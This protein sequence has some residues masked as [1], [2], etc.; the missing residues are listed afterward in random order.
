MDEDNFLDSEA[1]ESEEDGGG[2]DVSESDEEEGEQQAEGLI[3]DQSEESARGSDGE[4]DVEEKRKRKRHGKFP[5]CSLSLKFFLQKVSWF[6]WW[7]VMCIFRRR[8]FV[9]RR[10]CSA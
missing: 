6:M 7:F 5:H 4:I 1:E 10:L 9:R 3:N 8:R 2:D